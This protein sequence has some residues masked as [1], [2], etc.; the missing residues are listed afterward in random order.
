VPGATGGGETRWRGDEVQ[1]GGEDL[2]AKAAASRRTP[3]E[4]PK[5]RRAPCNMIRG[6]NDALPSYS[7]QAESGR[8]KG[9]EERCGRMKD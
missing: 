9:G 1:S 2:T 6:A 4:E 7:G 8:C 3:K 5:K